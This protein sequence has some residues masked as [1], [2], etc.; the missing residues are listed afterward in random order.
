M[1][2]NQLLCAL[3]SELQALSDDY[4]QKLSD[5]AADI[6]AILSE[7]QQRQI[8]YCF[9]L[10]D[11]VADAC[12]YQP[13]IIQ[14][15]FMPEHD[16]YRAIGQ[17]P[18]LI[19]ALDEIDSEADFIRAIRQMRKSLMVNIAVSNMLQ[20]TSIEQSFGDI[21]TLSDALILAAYRWAYQLVAKVNG[22]PLTATG[23][24]MPLSILGM[25]KLGGQELN[26]SSDIDLIFCYPSSDP[27][28]NSKNSGQT[29]GGR[30]SI[31]HHAFFIK[32]AQKLIHFLHHHSADGFVFRVDM[33]LRPFGDSGPLV[34]SYSAMENYYQAQ[35]RDWERYAML[36][37]RIIYEVPLSDQA[38]GEPLPLEYQYG[39]ELATL[40]R[41]FVYRRY[42]D[43]SV[44][45]SLRKM[46]QMISQ[47]ARRKN[48]GL[49]IKLGFGGIR[50]VEFI[51][52]VLQLI[53]GGREKQL[54]VKPLLLAL[55]RLREHQDID[56][57]QF[58]QLRDSYLVLR[59]CEQY[60]QVFNDQ[61]TQ[62]LPDD[63]L[64][65][66][67]LSVLF[68]FQSWSQCLTYLQSVMKTINDEFN[69]VI[70]DS[71]QDKGEALSPF[72]LF[73]QFINDPEREEE[74]AEQASLLFWLDESGRGEFIHRLTQFKAEIQKGL[75]GGRGKEVLD[76][77]IPQLLSG[78]QQAKES[79]QTLE[80]VLT[81]ISKIASRTVYLDLL[82]ENDGALKQLVKLCSQSRWVAEQLSY[83]PILLD[84]L[85]D[86][87][88]LY[89]P[90]APKQYQQALNQYMMRVPQDDLEQQLEYLRHFKLSQQL[91]I[92]AADISGVLSVSEVSTHLTAVAQAIVA[93]VVDIAWQ[94]MTERYGEPVN[95]CATN[96]GFGV[97]AYG[98][99]G[100]DELGYDSDLDVVFVHDCDSS[101]STNGR[102]AIDS[103]QFYLKLAQR[104]VHIFT[105]RTV[106][107]VLYEMDTRLRPS[108]NS[109]LM[110][111]NIN[112]YGSYLAEEAWTW[113]HQALVRSRIVYGSAELTQ[114]FNTIRRDILMQPRDL[115][116]LAKDVVE[117][118]A[119]MRD[120]L[121]KDSGVL[122]DLKQGL[123]G[124]ADIEF[125]T[126]FLVL[127][128]TCEQP[129]LSGSCINV[130]LF[131]LF[132]QYQIISQQQA[133][134]LTDSY[135]ALRDVYHQLTLQQQDKLTDSEHAQA[136]SVKIQQVW[137]EV[138]GLG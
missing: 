51:A 85:I 114:R 8:R 71:E 105:S 54:Q 16:L 20:Q 70:A 133:D 123:G 107:G 113:E 134:T 53:R 131:K 47:E 90:I 102:K 50:E 136:L 78:F 95:R 48:T 69:R 84:E 12:I 60:L 63:N 37:A 109:G 36:K 13:D 29:V 2:D 44:I 132:A 17:Y 61:Q 52:Q 79:S 111:I 137:G 3:P 14:H 128:H 104:L 59:Q 92:A 116:K 62:L 74:E 125:I 94:Q 67:R 127:A 15:V 89:N 21:S 64:N 101:Q 43:F 87:R 76:R 5:N 46:K 122:F 110:A 120:H 18:A 96:K 58:Y 40:L 80:R 24:P 118:R 73:W 45:D 103:R 98:K 124:I 77:L 93:C 82:Y 10:S 100:G 7:T 42:I 135:Q 19:R 27:N 6:V 34:L 49:N 31:D 91:R 22:Q 130:K 83:Q 88:V 11:F 38:Q 66:Q 25:G 138:F 108:G 55:Q 97:I 72:E 57:E 99:M 56:D 86:T 1:N 23:L 41:P 126:Q 68:G 65:Q 115:A 4:W 117:M 81:V 32:V 39:E 119:K 121:G 35:G 26:F 9:A 75:V 129:E 28:S 33:R 106:S 30:K 112:R